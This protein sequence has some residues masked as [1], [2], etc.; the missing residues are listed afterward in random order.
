[1]KVSAN[2]F[3][4]AQSSPFHHKIIKRGSAKE[5][6]KREK[7]PPKNIAQNTTSNAL[8]PNPFSPPP[9]PL[10]PSPNPPFSPNLSTPLSVSTNRYSTPQLPLSTHSSSGPS[11]PSHTTSV[12]P[13]L[14]SPG[15][16]ARHVHWTSSLPYSDPAFV[17]RMTSIV[18]R[19]QAEPPTQV[20]CGM[21]GV[22]RE[23][24]REAERRVRVFMLERRM[25]V[26]EGG[27]WALV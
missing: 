10:S 11:N 22:R 25:G 2:F 5:T 3:T 12:L 16:S 6:Q 4:P 14:N 26:W 1:M 8:S 13:S 17:Q 9:P 24:V 20:S 27:A 23:V 7:N 18:C 21:G 19:A 15:S